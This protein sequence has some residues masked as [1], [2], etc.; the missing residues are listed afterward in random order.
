MPSRCHK[1][2]TDI[3]TRWFAIRFNP[4][5]FMV[6]TGDYTFAVYVL[7]HS[8]LLAQSVEMPLINPTLGAQGTTDTTKA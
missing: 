3:V 8:L 2:E 1:P 4:D 6:H 5:D 7:S